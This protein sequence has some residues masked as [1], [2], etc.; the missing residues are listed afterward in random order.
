MNR[1]QLINYIICSIGA[2]RYL[3]IGIDSGEN[4]R[5]IICNSKVGV[6]PNTYSPA[7]FHMTSDDFFKHNVD[8]FDV[9][10]ID[11]LHHAEVVERDIINSLKFL[12]KGGHIVCHDMNPT[13]EIMQRVPREVDY[14]M[15]DCWKA[16][17]KLRSS[18]DKLNMYVVDT[19]CGCGVITRGSQ[20]KISISYPL[21]YEHLQLNRNKWLNLISVEEFK[22]KL[23][24]MS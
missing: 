21:I 5:H 1:S 11:G 12:T 24:Q 20:E 18:E 17:V 4:Y 7:T 6:D 9:I 16:W 13:S 14:W 23:G 19:D 22:T 3:E 8:T 2:T 15:G 10:F